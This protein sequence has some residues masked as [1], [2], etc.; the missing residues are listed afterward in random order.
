MLLHEIRPLLCFCLW[1]ESKGDGGRLMLHSR[2]VANAGRAVSIGLEKRY[3]Y[4][5]LDQNGQKSTKQSRT[6]T[7]SEM[8]ISR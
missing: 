6:H 7:L 2:G 1:D 5:S 3:K 4:N 8:Q